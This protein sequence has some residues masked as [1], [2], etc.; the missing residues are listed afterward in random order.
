[1]LVATALARLAYLILVR[2]YDLP[3]VERSLSF[4]YLGMLAESVRWLAAYASGREIADLKLLNYP[5]SSFFTAFLSVVLRGFAIGHGGVLILAGV[6]AALEPRARVPAAI[7]AVLLVAGH[8]GMA[9]TGWRY[10]YGYL[11]AP[12]GL[13]TAI[14]A[15]GLLGTVCVRGRRWRWTAV[16]VHMLLIL[17]FAVPERLHVDLYYGGLGWYLKRAQACYERDSPCRSY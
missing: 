10:H 6:A 16:V 5:G 9:I 3:S 7:A 15:A 8:A 12:A 13:M 1:M 4:S 11:S 14:A 17:G 2:L